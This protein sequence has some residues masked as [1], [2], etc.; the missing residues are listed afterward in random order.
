MTYG[1]G[2][3]NARI[4]EVMSVVCAARGVTVA[5]LKNQSRK[6]P[7]VIIRQEAMALSREL[8]GHSYPSIG[9]HFGDRDHTTALHAYRKIKAQEACSPQRQRDLDDMRQ[10]V[11]ALV[12]E[13]IA[14]MGGCSSTWSEPP[15]MPMLRPTVTTVTMEMAA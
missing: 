14:A 8:T 4:S 5:E 1:L 3:S 9:K 13:R 15:N 12:T 6:R 2:K 10:K 11:R 7:L